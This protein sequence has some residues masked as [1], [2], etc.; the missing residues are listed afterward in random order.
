L[1]LG[2]LDW[3]FKFAAIALGGAQHMKK[4]FSPAMVMVLC[5]V[6]VGAVLAV[7][8]FYWMFSSATRA[9]SEVLGTPPRLDF[10]AALLENLSTLALKGFFRSLLNSFIIASLTTLGTLLVASMAGF[11]LTQYQ[12][13]AREWIFGL[14]LLTLIVPPQVTIV[15][16]FQ[17]MAGQNPLG[18]NLLGSP[19][20]IVLPA[21]SSSFAIFFC[22]QALQK[23]PP[24]LSDAGRVDGANEWQVYWH[25][26]LPTIRPSLAAL[27]V[28]VFL[29]QWNAFFL[30]LIMNGNNTDGRTA[31]LAI[32]SLIGENQIDYGALLAAT[33]LSVLPVLVFFLFAQR[34][35]MSGAL[36][37]AV[38]G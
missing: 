9:S 22:R 6:A 11:A 16:L 7:F 18:L 12:F 35:F 4:S 37:G 32:S 1:G 13:R 28:F 25:I 30:P 2:G 38:K 33:A 27:S 20:A 14:F 8:P 34:L 21:L 19:W 15:P 26:A 31:P 23:Y 29:G 17:L 5:V 3:R 10:G 24:E 36:S